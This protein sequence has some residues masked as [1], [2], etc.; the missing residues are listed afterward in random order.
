MFRLGTKPQ[1]RKTPHFLSSL[2]QLMRPQ[3]LELSM[4]RG[5]PVPE[6]GPRE[7]CPGPEGPAGICK[8]PSCRPL[9]GSGS[10][11][12]VGEGRPEVTIHSSSDGPGWGGGGSRSDGRPV[13]QP[14]G[15]RRGH[16][17]PRDNMRQCL[18]YQC[19]PGLEEGFNTKVNISHARCGRAATRHTRRV[20]HATEEG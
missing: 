3:I 12:A 6:C 2:T 20:L 5:T 14:D 19:H 17:E 15:Q 4:G 11:G 8:D 18:D 10:P 1:T 7:L 9:Q 13:T 16:R